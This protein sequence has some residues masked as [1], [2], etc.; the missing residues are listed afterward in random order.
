M[1][2][3]GGPLSFWIPV[4]V[5]IPGSSQ[6]RDRLGPGAAVGVRGGGRAA[7]VI[8]CALVV[9]G[10]GLLHLGSVSAAD[11]DSAGLV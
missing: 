11:G 3:G 10:I 2:T 4:L 5:L 9:G 1:G 8:V 6:Q 7:A